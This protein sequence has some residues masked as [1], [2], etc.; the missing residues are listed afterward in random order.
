MTRK[1][2]DFEPLAASDPVPGEPDMIAALGRRYAQTAHEIQQQAA[3]LRRL[4]GGASAGWK[5][6]SG[7]VFAAKAEDLAARISRAHARYAAAAQALAHCA[8][9]MTD[10]QQRAYA[11]VW[12]AKD[13]E[14]RMTASA[15]AAAAA[16]EASLAHD[17]ASRAAALRHDEAS[18]DLSV[19]R[20]QFATAVEDYDTAAGAAA[21]AI[22]NEI[23]SDGLKDS[24]WDAHFGWFAGFFE[25]VAVTVLVLAV[26]AIILICPF[27][28]ALLGV[29]AVE[30]ATTTIGWTLF[31]LTFLQAAFDGSA[32]ATGKESWTA[33]AWDLAALATFGTGKAAEAGVAWLAENSEGIG[34]AIAGRRAGQ[35][36]MWGKNLPGFLFSLANRSSAASGVMRVLGMGGTLDTATKAAAQARSAV[37]AAV[38]SA[39][40]DAIASIFTMSNSFSADLSKLAAVDTK[41]PGVLRIRVSRTLA[42]SLAGVDGTFQWSTFGA[43]GYFTLHPLLA[44]S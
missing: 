17:P 8:T 23:G 44:G 33:F 20:R 21:R 5:G 39:S 4:A 24:W 10:A 9:P 1:P 28:V 41:V 12:Q 18:H 16:G 14:Q 30:A 19:A 2:P 40:P 22:T 32:T 3:N 31:G 15:P 35:A 43:G 27:S 29:A 26:V 25:I 6:K 11:A 34:K 37:Q 42:Q 36:A 7:T 38:R 13:A